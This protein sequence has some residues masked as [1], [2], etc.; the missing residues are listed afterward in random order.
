MLACYSLILKIQ[1]L[2]FPEQ[3]VMLQRTRHCFTYT[4]FPL[5]TTTGLFL[6]AVLYFPQM[7]SDGTNALPKYQQKLILWLK[8]KQQK[9][10]QQNPV[11]H[12]DP[13]AT[14]RKTEMCLRGSDLLEPW[15]HVCLHQAETFTGLDCGMQEQTRSCSTWDHCALITAS[16][17]MWQILCNQ[18]S[19]SWCIP[20]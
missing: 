3:N 19:P 20:H 14:N 4:E 5:L 18:Q 12:N 11:K 16:R 1:P 15:Q 2:S 6:Q 7:V 10:P 17:A 8:N 13:S 9:K